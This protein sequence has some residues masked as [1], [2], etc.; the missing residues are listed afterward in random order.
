MVKNL[1]ASVGDTGDMGLIPGLR[2]S[3]EQ[4]VATHFR[5]LAWNFHGQRSLVGYSPGGHEEVDVTEHTHSGY[6]PSSGIAGSYSSFLRSLCTVLHSGCINFHS[7][8]LCT[9]VL[10]SPHPLQ[11]FLFV[12][13]FDDGGH[14]DQCEVIP[15]SS[16]DLHFSNN[17]Q[18]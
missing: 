4:K 16:F 8:Q 6:M 5:I 10:F 1:P 18:C 12:D 14:S 17:E 7:H 13:F 11:H 9:R 3:L 15:S 2:R